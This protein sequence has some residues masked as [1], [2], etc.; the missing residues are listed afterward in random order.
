MCKNAGGVCMIVKH[1]ANVVFSEAEIQIRSL[2]T[3]LLGNA[4]TWISL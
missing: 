1:V 4:L 2:P 3:I